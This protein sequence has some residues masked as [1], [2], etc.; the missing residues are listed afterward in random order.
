MKSV[1][2]PAKN[3]GR[4]LRGSG[5]RK[6]LPSAETFVQG[7]LNGDR[8]LLSRAI[9]L[10]E[11]TL[12]AH[13]D[14]AEQVIEQCLPHS[15]KSIRIGITGIP[16]VGK[17]TFIESF[18]NLLIQNGRRLAVLTVD[19]TSQISK[20]SILGDKTRME[21]LSR[22][23]EAF[24]RPSPSGES[25]GGVARKTRETVFL[26]EAAGYDTIL[27]ETVGVGQ[28]ET[29]VHSMTDLFLL[30]LI[31]GAGDELQG[32]K[33]GIME[34]ADLI[35]ITKADG[36]NAS[37]AERAKA[38]TLSAIHFLPPHESGVPTNVLACSALT[39]KGISE[40]W[41]EILEYVETV[42]SNG[43]FRKNRKEQ[44]KY[45]LHESVQSL[46]V[47]DFREKTGTR[48]S[49]AE[50]KVTEGGISSLKAA[51]NLLDLY[52]KGK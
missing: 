47:E 24:I 13:Q 40:L 1:S 28:S 39:G 51:R 19:P 15:G 17:S 33:R 23:E 14:L 36:E 2:E 30:L 50:Q 22:K 37:H 8:V 18:G 21:T 32:I 31:A 12:P 48:Y 49:E 43:Y 20:G 4:F 5:P 11:S 27:I 45:W 3:E 34:M 38:E 25:L 6:V 46:L 26:C 52:R 41:K 9:T 35:A 29:A 7:I 10:V 42:T 44:A 16:G